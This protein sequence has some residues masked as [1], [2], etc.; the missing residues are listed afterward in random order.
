MQLALL[1]QRE[2]VQLEQLAQLVQRVKLERLARPVQQ[3]RPAPLDLELVIQ[4][5]LVLPALVR[6]A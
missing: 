1:A 4:V 2:L 3:E 5:P 6:P